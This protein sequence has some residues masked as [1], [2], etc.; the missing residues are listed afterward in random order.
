MPFYLH[1]AALTL[2]KGYVSPHLFG[3]G[4]YDVDRPVSA[5][6]WF[7]YF[8]QEVL[9]GQVGPDLQPIVDLLNQYAQPIDAWAPRANQNPPRTHA[10]VQMARAR[11]G[12]DRT[13]P[14]PWKLEIR[15]QLLNGLEPRIP[16]DPFNTLMRAALLAVQ[17]RGLAPVA[18]CGPSG[19]IMASASFP[20]GLGLTP[21]STSVNW[22][23]EQAKYSGPNGVLN[24]VKRAAA[25]I[26]GFRAVGTNVAVHT[27]MNVWRGMSCWA[28]TQNGRERHSMHRAWNPFS[29]ALLRSYLF[30]RPRSN[31]N[32][33]LTCTS[34]APAALEP[35][36]F[37]VTTG[38]PLIGN[39]SVPDK[40]ALRKTIRITRT[41]VLANRPV[42]EQADIQK[43]VDVS[44]SFLV[45]VRQGSY[46]FD[47]NGAQNIIAPG[48]GFPEYA[49][50]KLPAADILGCVTYVRVFHGDNGDEGYTAFPV[51]SASG[52]FAN[53]RLA[54]GAQA[55]FARAMTCFSARWL[56]VQGFVAA[57]LSQAGLGPGDVEIVQIN[58]RDIVNGSLVNYPGAELGNGIRHNAQGQLVV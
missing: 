24:Q 39:Y 11:F 14:F 13:T 49:V 57:P 31:D 22:G 37:K 20:P 19:K 35:D 27:V 36:V 56:P 26:V 40:Q 50:R 3:P 18:L 54:V 44:R 15:P 42:V 52:L 34:F 28:D 48:Q 1:D 16:N 53:A 33:L 9:D 6:A 45:C 10:N 17:R 23:G 47:T 4:V 5:I 12:R 2:N 55:L 32:C 46:F 58:G 8:Q 25:D 29:D 7:L 51:T 30:F 21:P 38:F 43:M 41:R